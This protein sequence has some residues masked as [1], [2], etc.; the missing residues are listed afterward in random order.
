MT[1]VAT[2]WVL[3]FA[4]VGASDLPRVGGKGANL[5][6]LAA[7][8]LPVPPGFCVTTDAYR[9][10]V[11]EVP[12][13]EGLLGELQAIA[14]EDV[15]GARRLGPRIRAAVVAR[16][17]PDDLAAVIVD[18]WRSLDRGCPV[19]VRSSATAEDLPEA[20]FAGQQDTFLNVATAEELLHKVRACWASLFT[21][22]AIL[23]RLQ[24][25]IAHADVALSVVVQRMVRPQKSGILFTADPV[26]NHRGITSIDAGFG[27]GEALVAGLI[28]ADRYRVD[29]ARRQI[30]EAAVGDKS[31]EIVSLPGGG[32][33][34]RALGADRRRARVLSDAEV[35]RLTELGQAV[36]DLYGGLP[37]DIEWCGDGDDLFVVQARPITSLYPLLAPPPD[38]DFLEVAI[39]LGHVQM[40]TDPMKPLGRSTIAHV[41]PVGRRVFEQRESPWI[42]SAGGRLYVEIGRALRLPITRRFITN[43]L[44][45]AD[46][47]MQA[48]IRDL[49]ARPELQ[50]GPRLSVRQLAPFAAFMLRNVLAWLLLRETSGVAATLE[51]TLDGHIDR[52]R[53]ELTESA[54]L[55]ERLA[56]ARRILFTLF[57][58]ML[59]CLPFLASGVIASR[60]LARLRPD[61]K[62][63]VD[64][65]ARGLVGNVTT[66]M[67]LAV[68]DLA[69]VARREPALREAMSR[70]VTDRAALRALPGGEAFDQALAAFLDRFGM[71]GPGEFDLTRPR[72]NEAP[73]SLLTMIRGN[74]GH[75]ELG[76]HRAHFAALRREAEAARD[77]LVASSARPKRRIVRRLAKVAR[78]ALP[79]RE[80]PKY[81][82]VRVFAMV[83]ALALEIGTRLVAQGRLDRPDDVFFLDY[84]EMEQAL[85]GEVS[86]LRDLVRERARAHARFAALR[87][88][89]VLASTGE[90]LKGSARSDVPAGALAGAGVSAGVVEGRARVVIDPAADVLAKGE[91]LVAP[92]TDPGWTPLFINAA[93]VVI[94]VGGMM[95][96]GSVIA[97]EYGIPAVVCVPDATTVIRSGQ[98]LR[99][100]GDA[101]WV[102]VLDDEEIEP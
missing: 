95:T 23:Y 13:F 74:L 94:E 28:N 53:L 14:P 30:V 9:A 101:G 8:G 4:A 32:T 61:A 5:G 1:T 16:P 77:R 45:F 87:P 57:G 69:D 67:D 66:E 60:L 99:I 50:A 92:Y 52:L 96:H 7:A 78:E 49:I 89:R 51:R 46:R 17:I 47:L 15:D 88:P 34:H 85:R 48:A 21:D 54:G 55:P 83:R 12:G 91:I 10:F 2:P 43:F 20:S 64:A 63:D 59:P 18:A 76:A 71:R 41:L 84:A 27:L 62:G 11:A 97:R 29:R 40:M 25:G 80:H 39:C 42:R 75:G 93:G 24:N 79:I 81:F 38:G 6:R 65:L 100:D 82:L 73:E 58:D 31:L 19:A 56:R 72:W 37:Q 70:G 33:E 102:Q 86:G 3:P 90:E 26:T 22:R 36:Q 44:G 98:R 68:G 35:H